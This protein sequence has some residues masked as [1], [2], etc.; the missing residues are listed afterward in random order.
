[1]GV[2]I[3]RS[4]NWCKYGISNNERVNINSISSTHDLEKLIFE[5]THILSNSSSRI[6]FTCTNQP[7]LV[8]DSDTHP[9]LHTNRHHQV[10][11][12][13]INL[14]VEY[15]PPYQKH[16]WNYAKT[17]KYAILSALK[18]V[19]W[20]RLFTNKTAQKKVNL[21]NDIILNV[22]T[23]FAPNKVITCDYRDPPSINDNIKNKIK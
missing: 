6:D 1:M 16:V 23:N 15:P 13:K 12:C 22:V 18:N 14:Q 4:S 20:H 5:P 17:N 21:L 9:S 3:A 7:N 2:F 19:D 8:V 10:I 11:C